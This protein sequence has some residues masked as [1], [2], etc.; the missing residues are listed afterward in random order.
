MIATS[1]LPS[2]AVTTRP[3]TT[4]SKTARSSSE[5]RG[6]ATHCPSIRATRTRADRAAEGQP[7][8]LGGQRRAV[9]RDHVVQVVRVE[10]EHGVD[11]LD[12]VAQALDERRAQRPVDQPA[13]EDRVRAS[14]GPRGGRTSRGSGPTAYIRS[15]T[16]TVEREEVE[17][18][19]RLLAGG[20]G[21]QDHRVAVE[22]DGT[23]EPAACRARRPGLEPDGAGAERAVVDDGLGESDFGTL[24]GFP[25]VLLFD[26]AVRAVLPMQEPATGAAGAGPGVL[27][28]L[29]S[30]PSGR[31][32]GRASRGPLPRTG[33]GTGAA[34]RVVL[35]SCSASAPGWN[36]GRARTRERAAVHEDRGASG[37][38]RRPRRSISAR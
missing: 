29:R 15:S 13:G 35:G 5:C 38:R 12:L 1:W 16:S 26:P 18:V 22:V 4:M 10:R 14:G 6:K 25:S 24:H 30:R 17:L 11:D 33:A 19:L 23:A 21:R 34:L 28:G 20:G 9:D 8:Q 32:T 37:H 3:A 31:R 27:S 7:G 2:S 36:S